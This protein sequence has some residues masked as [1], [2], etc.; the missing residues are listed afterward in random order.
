MTDATEK[1][2]QRAGARRTG[3]ALGLLINGAVLYAVNVWP[4]WQAVPYLTDEAGQLLGLVNLSLIAGMFTNAIYLI[5]D[6]PRLKALGDLVTLGIGIA[7]LVSVWQVFPFAFP[8][9]FDWNLIARI[10]LVLSLIGSVIGILVQLV[11]LITGR[12]GSQR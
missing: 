12:P 6:Y 3:Y 4:G 10:V 5:V 11:I 9:G 8:I 1:R 2:R 7:V